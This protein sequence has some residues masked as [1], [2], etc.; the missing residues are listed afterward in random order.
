[1]FRRIDDF[2]SYWT[3]HSRETE[4]ILGPLTDESLSQ[5][6]TDDHRTIGRMVWHMILTLPGMLR[7]AGLEAADPQQGETV[8]KSAEEI[9]N[10]YR[11][12]AAQVLEQVKTSWSDDDLPG[13]IEIYGET[14][15]RGFLLLAVAAHEIHHRGQLTVLMRQAGLTVPGVYGPAK[16]EWPNYGM[17]VPAI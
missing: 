8:P 1:M 11:D 4:K 5:Q 14:W 9:R 12:M 15:P 3:D 10:A 2:V 17:Q 13:T 6:V 16:E 7:D